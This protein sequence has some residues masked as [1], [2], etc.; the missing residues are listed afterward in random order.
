MTYR[1]LRGSSRRK[2]SSYSVKRSDS[3][4]SNRSGSVSRT[5]SK[6]T[7]HEQ[8]FGYQIS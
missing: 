2:C 6:S 4:D 7:L 1:K 8:N 5:G 3:G